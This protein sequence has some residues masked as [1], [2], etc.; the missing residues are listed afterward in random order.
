MKQALTEII[1]SKTAARNLAKALLSDGKGQREIGEELARRG[2]VST[3]T[4]QALTQGGVSA[5]LRA[6][7]AKAPKKAAAAAS[8]RRAPTKDPDLLRLVRVLCEQ[9][10]MPAEDRL[11]AIS[12]LLN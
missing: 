10:H 3:K 12:L 9:R 2:W 6:G 8:K 7:R 4:K 11:A 1:T 5:L